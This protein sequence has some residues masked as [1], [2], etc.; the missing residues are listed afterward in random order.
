MERDNKL[1]HLTSARLLQF[2]LSTRLISTIPKAGA[3]LAIAATWVCIILLVGHSTGYAQQTSATLVGTLTDANGAVVLNAQIKVTNLATGSARE[4][5]S[6]GAGNYSFSFL[7]AGNYELTITA[8]GYKTKKI[9]R[10]TLQ[11]SQTLRQDF[12]MEIGAVSETVNIT[13]VGVQLQ[14]ENSTVGTVIDSAKIVELPLNGRNF[15]QLAQ[16]IPGVQSGTPGSITVRRGRGSIGQQDPAF[17]STAMSANGSRDTANRFF[18]D[19][20]EAMDHDAETYSFSPSIDSLAEFKVETST[21]SAESGGAPGGQ[22]NIVTKRG[23]NQY[24]GTLWEFNRNDALTQSYDAIAQKEVNPPRLNRN[25]FGANIGGPVKLPRF[26][27]GGPALYDGKDKTHFFF[28]WERGRLAQGV[29]PSLC[30]Q[31]RCAMAISGSWSMR[32]GNR[33]H[34]VIQ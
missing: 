20:I 22:V 2:P 33:L 31:Q 25:Q 6:D 34:C 17:A 27:I 1:M 30:R 24:H 5:V 10:L 15:V 9:D 19:G 28:N 14:T 23:G 12:A 8:A 32:R 7:P 13:A 26:G 18:I 11:V 16:L 4:A 3:R 21:Y 29:V